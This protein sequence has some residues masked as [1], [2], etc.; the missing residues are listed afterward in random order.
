[1]SFITFGE[2]MLRLAQA[3]PGTSIS[4]ANQFNVDYAGSESNVASSLGLLGNKVSYVTRLPKNELGDAAILSLQKYGVN[5]CDIQQNQDE[6][7]GIYFIESGYSLRPSKVIYDRQYSAIS[8]IKEKAFDWQNI[9]EGKNWLFLSGITAALSENCAT[10]TLRA[11]KIAKDKGVKVAFD[12]NYRRT[13]WKNNKRALSFYHEMLNHTDLLFG[14]AGS[15]YDV[16]QMEANATEEPQRTIE[17]AEM[18]VKK[19]D[20]PMLGFTIRR[21]ISATLNRVSA[22][23]LKNSQ[24]FQ[25]TEYE[26]NILDRFGS[27]DAFAAGFLHAINKEWK[28]QKII[29]FATASFALKHTIAG[30][31][32]KSAEKEI[33]SVASGNISGHVLR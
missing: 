24:I 32:H 9:L 17:I 23:L 6:R 8:Q 33:L 10:E 25:A 2:I 22:V 16:F 13:L 28:E 1:M 5:T 20:I 26:V 3:K 15:V 31:Q 30:D 12:L 14:N 27:G 7:L 21:H 11:A 19:F 29:D 18:V 4:F